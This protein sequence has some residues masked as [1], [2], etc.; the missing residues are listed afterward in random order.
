MLQQ[1]NFWACYTRGLKEGDEIDICNIH[2]YSS[3]VYNNQVVG[4]ICVYLSINLFGQTK[5]GKYK[6]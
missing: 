1:S 2:T 4:A 6:K 3:I 5:C